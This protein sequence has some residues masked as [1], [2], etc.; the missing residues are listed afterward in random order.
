MNYV[1]DTIN[2][3]R[4][5]WPTN[6]TI[7]FKVPAGIPASGK[8]AIAFQNTPF[9][10]DPSFSFTDVDLAVSTTSPAFGYV[11]RS[12]AAAPDDTDDGVLV[13]PV[14]GPVTITLSSGRGYLP[15]PMCA[16]SSARTLPRAITRS[17]IRRDR[18]IPHTFEYL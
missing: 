1:S 16:W 9:L 17:R 5:S 12:L 2:D 7:V 15:D 18:F 14:M 6:H 3:S 4:L 13:T 11:E 8:I 10:I